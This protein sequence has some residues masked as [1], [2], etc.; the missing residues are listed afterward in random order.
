MG[1]T[2]NLRDGQITV[3]DGTATPLEVTLT[4]EM[5]DLEFEI[6]TENVQVKDR[7]NLDHVRPGDQMPS[8]LSFSVKLDRMHEASSPVTLYNAL[9]ATGAASSWVTVGD[10]WEPYAVE[11]EFVVTDPAGGSDDETIT[12]TKV[13][14]E[15]IKYTEG[16]DF[17]VV[18]FS[19][20]NYATA[21]TF[22]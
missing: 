2:R 17:N 1:Q 15:S 22:S 10:A 3:R 11:V 12:F 7:G 4:L 8:P 14:K 20:F 18:A 13:F 16:A 21:P 6:V 19:G 9:T 5:G